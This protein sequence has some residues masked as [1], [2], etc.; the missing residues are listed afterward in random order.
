[1]CYSNI[2]MGEL[3]W[4][5]CLNLNVP[6]IDEKLQQEGIDTISF[7]HMYLL[8]IALP[9]I[10]VYIFQAGILGPINDHH[11]SSPLQRYCAGRFHSLVTL[12]EES[13]KAL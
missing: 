7:F 8:N 11:L 6:V 3:Q 1:M 2:S 9:A 12:A 10:I 5:K 13:W 4:R